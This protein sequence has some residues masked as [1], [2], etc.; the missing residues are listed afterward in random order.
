ME[1]RYLVWVIS[2]ALYIGLAT[3]WFCW[4]VRDSLQI[5]RSS[6]SHAMLSEKE[7]AEH[8]SRKSCWV[9][10][11]GQAYDLTDFLDEHPG[12]SD[13]ILRY[14]GRVSIEQNL[15]YLWHIKAGHNNESY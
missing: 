2:A 4:A 9:I 10:I 12:G 3:E 8:A 7:V 15:M 5:S 11:E 1:G 6:Q 13:V 14:A